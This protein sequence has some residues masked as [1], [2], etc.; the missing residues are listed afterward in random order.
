MENA[1]KAL[2]IAGGVLISILILSALVMMWGN[3]STMFNS[4]EKVKAS[5]QVQAFNTEYESFNKKLLR[6]TEVI[7]VINRVENN[8]RTYANGKIPLTRAIKQNEMED[9]GYYMNVEFEMKEAIIYTK[10]NGK[11]KPTN[12]E[13]EVGKTYSMNDFFEN[14]KNDS[15][16]FTDFKRRI[17]DCTETKYNSKTGRINYMK[18]VERKMTDN[19][20]IEGI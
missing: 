12:K 8:N 13:F 18:F 14:I 3:T 1:S 16:A 7:S 4:Q 5:E 15:D 9:P 10:L 17:F 2:Y 20:Y 6:G 11:G 19:E